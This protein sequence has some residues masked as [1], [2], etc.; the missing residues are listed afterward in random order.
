MTGGAH[1]NEKHRNALKTIQMVQKAIVL[2]DDVVT[3][4][5]KMCGSK[6]ALEAEGINV[7]GMIAG[8]EFVAKGQRS[9]ASR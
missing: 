8:A 1:K 6:L 4:G 9:D 3:S 5:S 2:F 7:I